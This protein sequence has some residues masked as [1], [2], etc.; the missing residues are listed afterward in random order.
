VISKSSSAYCD[1]MVLQVSRRRV[2]GEKGKKDKQIQA[3]IY[4]LA[5]PLVGI[6]FVRRN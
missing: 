3:V 1:L 2:Q 6:K 4:F 5:P